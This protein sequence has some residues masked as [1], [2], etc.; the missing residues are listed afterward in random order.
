VGKAGD[1]WQAARD[2]ALSGKVT[3]ARIVAV[4]ATLRQVEKALARPEGLANRPWMR[5]LI[6]A[7]D[8]DNGYSDVAFPSVVEAWQDKNDA[9]TTSELADLVQR[10]DAAAA[11]LG[12]ATAQLGQR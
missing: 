2:Q 1:Q 12:Q 9:R 11:L 8:R 10:M 5:N 7:S 3:K 4:N 6:F